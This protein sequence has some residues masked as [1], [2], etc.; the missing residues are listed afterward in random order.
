[1]LVSKQVVG[2]YSLMEFFLLLNNSEYIKIKQISIGTAWK[3]LGFKST[4]RH[5]IEKTNNCDFERKFRNIFLLLRWNMSVDNTMIYYHDNIVLTYSFS[6]FRHFK[7]LWRI[8]GIRP[9]Y[10]LNF[11]YYLPFGLNR[12]II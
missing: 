11:S 6:L 12:I 7:L 2:T 10:N 4:W 8:I 1:M 9:D 5:Y 3:V